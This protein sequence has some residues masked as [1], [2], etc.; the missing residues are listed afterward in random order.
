MVAGLVDKL[1]LD[2]FFSFNKIKYDN[3]E[4]QKSGFFVFKIA[5]LGLQA[6]G[7]N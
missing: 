1:K 7:S 6:L 3:P 4:G 5:I 2:K